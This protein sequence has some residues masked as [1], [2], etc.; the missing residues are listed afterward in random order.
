MLGVNIL[1]FSYVLGQYFLVDAGFMN[2]EGF[3]APYRGQRYHLNEW[4]SGYQPT[5]PEELFNM[6]HS[7]ARNIIE[8]CFGVL[9]MR[10]AILRSPPFY[11]IRTVNGI[12]MACCLLHNLIRREMAIDPMEEYYNISGPRRQRR[13]EEHID[14]IESSDE[15]RVKRDQLAREM[16][17]SWRA[18]RRQR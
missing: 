11:P 6:K 13:D 14:T 2:C 5:T 12:V 15:W 4:R 10:W 18:S 7:S 16:F 9:K 3:L 17:D 1:A 8:R